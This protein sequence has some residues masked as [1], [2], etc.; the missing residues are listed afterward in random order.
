[1]NELTVPT[2]REITLPP[3]LDL[4]GYEP[5]ECGVIMHPLGLVI[6]S[7]L[8]DDFGYMLHK[9]EIIGKI[10][11]ATQFWIGDW[12]IAAEY[13][14]GEMYAQAV[15]MFG[16]SPSTLA[17]YVWTCR[18]IPIGERWPLPVSYTHHK[19]VST[20]AIPRE[21][22]NRLLAM[23][24]GD[25]RLLTT[26]EFAK[27]LPYTGNFRASPKD[28][29]V[30]VIMPDLPSVSSFPVPDISNLRVAGESGGEAGGRMITENPDR[31]GNSWQHATQRESPLYNDIVALCDLG[32]PIL[33]RLMAYVV[34]GY[35]LTYAES[36][37]LNDFATTLKALVDAANT[38]K[39]V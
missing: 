10:A 11:N 12:I 33:Q 15:G 27:L 34:S 26:K 13:K 4:A 9:A 21:E 20:S 36:N 14:Y 6:T 35:S 24:G 23:V 16:R 29:Q 22:R 38:K 39:V 3:P 2:S 5:D 28:R 1:M 18:A 19:L 7:R 25:E 37:L 17:N 31:K 30:G 32:Y 8:P